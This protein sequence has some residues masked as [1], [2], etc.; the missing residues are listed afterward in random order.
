MQQAT[1]AARGFTKR[2]TS[3]PAHRCACTSL[4]PLASIS[5]RGGASALTG[6]HH[7]SGMKSASI[8]GL[9]LVCRAGFQIQMKHL[10]FRTVHFNQ[11]WLTVREWHWRSA[12]HQGFNSRRDPSHTRTE[13]SPGLL[14]RPAAR[15]L[16]RPAAW[17]HQLP[18]CLRLNSRRYPPPHTR[19][20]PPPGLIPGTA[21]RL[22]QRSTL[23][24]TLEPERN[25]KRLAL[26][27]RRGLPSWP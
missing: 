24:L 26:T 21:A 20:E 19:T 6:C 8:G 23:K 1:R 14:P 18:T 27:N 17:L 4:P 2:P 25:R 16:A 15:L 9:R 5:V 22:R 3:W 7:P 11:A 13:S 10:V 12:K